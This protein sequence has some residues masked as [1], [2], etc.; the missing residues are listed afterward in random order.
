VDAAPRSCADFENPP[1]Q[2][3]RDNGCNMQK[4]LRFRRWVHLSLCLLVG[5]QLC[6]LVVSRPQLLRTLAAFNT[7]EV[8]C[9]KMHHVFQKL[10]NIS[11]QRLAECH[12]LNPTMLATVL[13]MGKETRRVLQSCD[14]GASG[15]YGSLHTFRQT[16]YVHKCAGWR[17]GSFPSSH[18]H[19]PATFVVPSDGTMKGLGPHLVL[20]D[21]GWWYWQEKG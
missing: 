18:I 2:R 4:Q 8:A 20:N 5:I 12:V 3:R 11:L 7:G 1:G 6:L 9:H 15:L 13:Y 19:V 21:C 14:V 16:M 17:G 10:R